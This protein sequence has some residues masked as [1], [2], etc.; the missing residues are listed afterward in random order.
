MSFPHVEFEIPNLLDRIAMKSELENEL[1][2][3]VNL[4]TNESIHPLDMPAK[5]N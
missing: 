3:P 5:A 2:I 4:L 1:S